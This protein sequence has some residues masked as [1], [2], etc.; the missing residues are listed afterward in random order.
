MVHEENIRLCRE[1]E[2]RIRDK[3]PERQYSVIQPT[4]DNY[5][6]WISFNG[7]FDG[8]VFNLG[9]RRKNSFYDRD[10]DLE[11]AL[12]DLCYDEG[13]EVRAYQNGMPA[14]VRKRDSGIESSAIY[15]GCDRGTTG[16]G[17]R[18]QSYDWEHIGICW[19]FLDN[20]CNNVGY[21]S[22]E[23]DTLF[24][25]KKWGSTKIEEMIPYRKGS[26]LG[27]CMRSLVVED[28]VEGE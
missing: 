12:F 15:Y 23:G 24:I 2:R 22:M 10:S 1:F 17:L 13:L 8:N 14:A 9:V 6:F 21:F 27:G 11:L 3:F 26:H 16:G 19:L 25:W 4:Q 18:P 28:T 7:K 5:P 20:T